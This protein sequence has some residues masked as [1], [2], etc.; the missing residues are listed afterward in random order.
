M[1]RIRVFAAG[2]AVLC[3]L[4]GLFLSLAGAADDY[5]NWTPLS[6][7]LKEILQGKTIEF[8]NV[9]LKPSS[10]VQGD[11]LKVMKDEKGEDPIYIVP[12]ED[13]VYL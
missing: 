11:D 10:I 5:S 9:Q 1:G 12:S 13:K 3:I 6:K 2:A 8:K 4:L 7:E